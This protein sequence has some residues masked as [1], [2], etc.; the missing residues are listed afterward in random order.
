MDSVAEA[1]GYS[2][3]GLPQA[4]THCGSSGDD[5]SDTSRADSVPASALERAEAWM[6]FTLPD[7]DG[8]GQE[9][10]GIA[11]VTENTSLDDFLRDVL[12]GGGAGREPRGKGMAK[13]PL[14]SAAPPN[15]RVASA[16]STA[17]QRSAPF[18]SVKK[19]KQKNS[20]RKA[21]QHLS[22]YRTNSISA[23]HGVVGN[24]STGTSQRNASPTL[25]CPT[26]SGR[27]ETSRKLGDSARGP[28]RQQPRA[29]ERAAL[30]ALGLFIERLS[31]T[32]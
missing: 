4:V 20:H 31:N 24:P 3:I 5:E 29:A 8:A 27:W 32:Q 15:G 7:G 13:A 21:L 26:C 1:K 12:V 25:T 14:G 6:A 22:P 28:T 16:L 9:P 2:Q 17:G 11:E 23:P 18:Q 19:A 10:R 30:D